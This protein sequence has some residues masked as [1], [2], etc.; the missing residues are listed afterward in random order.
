MP[1]W[2]L[3]EDGRLVNL[4]HIESITID[5]LMDEDK[6]YESDREHTH[7]IA[8]SNIKGE[9][10]ILYSGGMMACDRYLQIMQRRLCDASRPTTEGSTDSSLGCDD[11]RGRSS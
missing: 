5:E 10:Y 2:I 9:Y 8:A 11:Q 7:M 6:T 4:D 3:D 1:H